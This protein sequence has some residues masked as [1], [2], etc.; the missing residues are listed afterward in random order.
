[1]ATAP[2]ETELIPDVEWL[3]CQTERTY[4]VNQYCY[5]KE[6]QAS[7][8]L[9]TLPFKLWPSQ[10]RLMLTLGSQRLVLIL[11]A[12]QLGISWCVCAYVLHKAFFEKGRMTLL[13]SKGQLEA[14]DL[15][16][17]IRFMY[18]NL[19][20]WMRRIGPSITKDNT[21]E[22]IF[23]NGS[24]ILSLPAAKDSGRSLTA[25]VVVLDEAAFLQFA[26]DIYTGLK[27]TIDGG[28]QMIILSTANGIG[29]LF[30]QLWVKAQ[31]KLNNYVAVFLPWWARP[32]RDQAWYD[33]TLSDST[34]PKL[35][36]QEYPRTADEAFLVS[37]RTRFE[38]EW[39]DAQTVWSTPP[40]PPTLVPERLRD[41]PGL[42]IWTPPQHGG[43]YVI[44]ADVAEGLA[45]GDFSTAAV[46]DRVRWQ[47][48]AEIHGHLEPSDFAIH[49][50]TLGRY[51]NFAELAPERNNHGHAVL[52]KLRELDYPEISLG[53]DQR[54]GWQTTIQSKPLMID[55]LATA[56]KDRLVQI[57][58]AAAVSEMRLLRIDDKG[59]VGAPSGYYDDR[60]LAHAISL[61]VAGR[62]DYS[63]QRTTSNYR[64]G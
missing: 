64:T 15:L 16:D 46:Y 12:R 59:R 29:N 40:L 36:R 28:G 37:G 24:R 10:F 17:R 50:D 42:D 56:L 5:I 27:P 11:K 33:R 54:Q 13:L 63:G 35:V 61:Y 44:G 62:P 60:V 38:P 53:L 57:R 31:S 48:V 43:R 3:V 2:A 4:F 7:G 22:I 45:H 55:F 18:Q 21:T 20:D 32:G 23:S 19:P 26:D 58:S 25:S 52:A 49:L 51:Y 1:M 39:L 8:D 34:N 30:H 9:T 14:N 6:P 41:I 47:Q